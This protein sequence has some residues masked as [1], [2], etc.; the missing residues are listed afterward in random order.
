[1]KALALVAVL[2]LLGGLV[3]I[4]E[5]VPPGLTLEFAAEDAG[6]VTFSGTAHARAGMRCAN[7]HLSIFD[8]SRSAMITRADH[9]TDQFCFGCHDGATAFAARGNC[10]EC[11]QDE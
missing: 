10:H 7:C 4:A 9:R 2:A 8:V 1:M 3:E 6:Q 5:A 11:H